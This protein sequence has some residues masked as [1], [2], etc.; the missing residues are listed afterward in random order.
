MEGALH[1]EQ[2]D[3]DENVVETEELM[4]NEAHE[5]EM[6]II[7]GPTGNL[8]D[9][10]FKHSIGIIPYALRGQIEGVHHRLH[11]MIERP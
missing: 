11:L 6:A 2:E 3:I 4:R 10:R 1:R 9:A 8:E 7:V 5:V